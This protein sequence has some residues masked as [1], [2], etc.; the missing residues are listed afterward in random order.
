M[1]SQIRDRGNARDV[2]E[3]GPE[4]IVLISTDLSH[5]ALAKQQYDFSWRINR[6][7]PL[8]KRGYR[9]VVVSAGGRVNSKGLPVL[10]F[11]PRV[12]QDGG[13]TVISPPI[14][15]VPLLWLLQ[16]LV[17]TPLTVLLY[18]RTARLKISAIV[19][20]TVS[21]GAVG[22]II[23]RFARAPLIVDYGDPDFARERSFALKLLRGLELFVFQRQGVSA[24]TYI[25][26]NIGRYLRRYRPVKK[27]FLPPGGFWRDSRRTEGSKPPGQDK[28]VLYSGHIAPPPTYRL[29]LLPVAAKEVLRLVPKTKFILVGSGSY[30]ARLEKETKELGIDESFKFV[31][32]V[33]YEES[34]T[35]ISGCDVALQLLNDMCLGTKVM[36]YFALGKAVIASGRFFDSYDSFLRTEGNCILIPPD[37]ER[38]ASEL[39]RLLSDDSLRTKL[40]TSARD[41]VSG[42]DYESQSEQ[43]LKLILEVRAESN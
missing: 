4:A 38:L 35:N 31:G 2:P 19:C 10:G 20:S 33:P 42:Y 43:L 39:V 23:N 37:A 16:S 21:Y 27:L 22:K 12:R 30:L 8:I 15:R 28:M 41:S 36:D 40:G 11:G 24:V 29:D 17:V 14:V 26:P 7:R 3:A 1:K 6:L 13:L 32:A 34:L 18:C 5:P 9:I 25:D